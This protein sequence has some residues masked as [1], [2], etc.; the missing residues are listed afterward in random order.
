MKFTN[1]MIQEYGPSLYRF[2]LTL[3][4]AKDLADDLYQETFILALNYSQEIQ[5]ESFRSLLFRLA[6][7]KWK[8]KQ[9]KWA[10]RNKLAPEV[11]SEEV[12]NYLVDTS[13]S[14]EDQVMEKQ[15]ARDVNK[16]ILDLEDAYR[17]VILL[18]Y[19]G[20]YSMKEIADLLALPEGTVKSRLYYGKKKLKLALKEYEND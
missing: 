5:E 6:H 3:T 7:R 11:S 16:A 9:R 20:D 14:P 1:E 13:P 8:D 10:R 12:L 15:R 17:E 2:C 19:M 4:R 18:F